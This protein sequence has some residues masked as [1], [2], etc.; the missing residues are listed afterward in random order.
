MPGFQP[1]IGATLLI[2]SGPGNHL[3]VIVTDEL[4]GEYLLVSI[5]TIREGRYHDGT[6]ELDA[7]IHEFVKYDSYA[8]YGGARV[9]T[10]Q[11]LVAMEGKGVFFAKEDV[12]PNVVSAICDG[13]E[14][15]AHTP[16]YAIKFYR[17][18]LRGLN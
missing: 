1:H 16:N 6:C 10:A 15:S 18:Y 13:I 8:H 11:H 9:I 3:F 17:K 5:S 2:P 4:D 12:P 14:I 7:G